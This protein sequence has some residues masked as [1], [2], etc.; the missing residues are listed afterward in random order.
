MTENMVHPDTEAVTALREAIRAIIDSGCS[1]SLSALCEAI[2]LQAED[3]LI[4]QSGSPLS[5]AKA[6]AR[7]RKAIAAMGTRG[8]N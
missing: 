4:A 7:I 2:A 6:Q 8:M 5:R 1:Y 3:C